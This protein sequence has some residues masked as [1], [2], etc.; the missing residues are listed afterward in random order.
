M[1]YKTN[2]STWLANSLSW[3]LITMSIH[4]YC[5]IILNKSSEAHSTLHTLWNGLGFWP[6][7]DVVSHSG[8]VA[9]SLFA[10]PE[11][12]NQILTRIVILRFTRILTLTR[13]LKACMLTLF[14]S[15]DECERVEELWMLRCVVHILR[16]FILIYS[17]TCVSRRKSQQ[18]FGSI[19]F[20]CKQ[21]LMHGITR[22][23]WFTSVLSLL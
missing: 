4:P 11:W 5:S 23:L 1:L 19:N 13:L 2:F 15:S 6:F 14:S 3:S 18:K 17:Y 21:A 12:P 16:T 8:Y 10:G 7:R 20:K 9:V 22:I